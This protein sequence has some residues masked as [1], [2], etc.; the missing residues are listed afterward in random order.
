MSTSPFSN[1]LMEVC[2]VGHQSWAQGKFFQPALFRN[3]PQK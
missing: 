3:F 2:E 1:V